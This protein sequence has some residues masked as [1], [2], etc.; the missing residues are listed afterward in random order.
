MGL[1]G[2]IASPISSLVGIKMQN[3]AA[4][5]RNNANIAF[6]KEANAMNLALARESFDYQKELNELTMQ[7]EDTAYQRLVKDLKAAGLSPALALG[8]GG[9]QTATFNSSDLGNVKAPYSEYQSNLGAIV[10]SLPQFFLDAQEQQARIDNIN[11][12][13][14]NINRLTEHLDFSETMDDLDMA[15]KRQA[16]S[17]LQSGNA[18]SIALNEARIAEITENCNVLVAQCEKVLADTQSTKAQTAKAL[19][20]LY[21]MQNT[22]ETRIKSL[23]LSNDKLEADIKEKWYELNR[24][25]NTATSS[26]SSFI[27]KTAGDF[28]AA[29]QSAGVPTA[30]IRRSKHNLSYD[31]KFSGK[32]GV[33]YPV[34]CDEFVPGDIV[35]ISNLFNVQFAPMVAPFMDDVVAKCYYFFVPNRITWDKWENFLK[36]CISD[37]VT[38]LARPLKDSDNICIPH[39]TDS[40]DTTTHTIEKNSIG[41]FILG[42]VGKYPKDSAPVDFPR[43]GLNMIF[44]HYFRDEKLDKPRD[45]TDESL[46]RVRWEKDYFTSANLSAQFGDPV[47]LPL[48]GFAPIT[49]FLRQTGSGL[50][51]YISPTPVLKGTMGDSVGQHQRTQEGIFE[52]GGNTVILTNSLDS[53]ASYGH[54]VSATTFVETATSTPSLNSAFFAGNGYNNGNKPNDFEGAIVGGMW[55][56][57][58]PTPS[59]IGAMPDSRYDSQNPS[60]YVST[61][62]G[63]AVGLANQFGGDLSSYLGIF[64]V[65]DSDVF[66]HTGNTLKYSKELFANRQMPRQLVADLSRA[67]TFDISDLRLAKQLQHWKELVNVS[68]LRYTEYLQA[69]YGVHLNDDRVQEPI[70]LG[71]TKT[72]IVSNTVMQTAGDTDTENPTPIG[73]RYGSASKSSGGRV[74][75]FHVKEHGYIFGLFFIKPMANYAQGIN[76][77]FIKN[78][79]SDFFNPLFTNIGDQEIFNEEIFVDESSDSNNKAI[80]GFQARNNEMRTKQN[81]IC[82]DMRDTLA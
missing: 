5:S 55:K 23:Q 28:N 70:Y 63:G 80:F 36:Q 78:S 54:G 57:G 22:Y 40:D 81:M 31:K 2:D 18:S 50:A 29:I 76:R 61:Y 43:R 66:E 44:N 49:D 41:D 65:N 35:K 52:S 25:I 20:E 33:C 34:M 1:L 9:S 39:W 47:A 8:S 7:R 46:F 71:S 68:G 6:Q 42:Y 27:G 10:G 14:S 72:H 37:P 13:T 48:S 26:N 62:L 11:A 53:P 58:V 64:G 75:T 21:Q 77:Q 24:K 15:L 16:E 19:E 45:L 82:S 12:N 79:W 67:G 60:T 30:K 38:G 17:R 73:T 3:D 56:N 74:C 69:Q 51:E 4:E 59:F 32:L